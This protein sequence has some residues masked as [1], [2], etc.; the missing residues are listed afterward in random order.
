MPF[1]WVLQHAPRETLGIIAG[2][3]ESAGGAA[4]TVRVFAGEPVPAQMTEAAGLIVLGGPMGVYESA[5]FP[6]LKQ[7]L[8][9]IEQALKARK[10]ILGICLG[11]Q[12]LAVALGAQ[13]T[14]GRQKEIGW[15]TVTLTEQAREDP[16]WKGVEPAFMGFHWH[17]DLFE[18]PRGAGLLASSVLTA[19]QAYRYG[20]N[21]YGLL[22][23]IEVTE[24]II[25]GM[26]QAFADE[27]KESGADEAEIL[28]GIQTHLPRLQ[29]VGRSVFRRWVGLLNGKNKE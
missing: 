17:G 25:R 23:H 4:R 9:L 19:R 27:L 22:F 26:V 21:A 14:K 7:E 8:R 20:E 18:V 13:V 12:L 29:R 10:P 16:L 2:A 24:E 3:L 6:F 5:L 28:G 15:R 1:V 11:S